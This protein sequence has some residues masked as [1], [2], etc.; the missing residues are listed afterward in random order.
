MNQKQS[1][2]L[3]EINGD[4]LAVVNE[5]MVVGLTRHWAKHEGYLEGRGY[6][7][8]GWM[9]CSLNNTRYWFSHRN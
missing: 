2:M 3:D 6:E 1:R 7:F 9:W 4:Y 8:E 5:K